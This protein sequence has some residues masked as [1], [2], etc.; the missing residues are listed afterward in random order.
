MWEVCTCRKTRQKTKRA[1]KLGQSIIT[2]IISP[3]TSGDH[4]EVPDFRRVESNECNLEIGLL[5]SLE[6]FYL[7]FWI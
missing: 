6:I 2:T 7:Q 3:Q 1:P 4:Q 5:P